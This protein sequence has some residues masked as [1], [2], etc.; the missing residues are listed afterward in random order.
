LHFLPGCQ[1]SF[2]GQVAV[3]TMWLL[4][5]TTLQLAGRSSAHLVYYLCSS[6]VPL[7]FGCR[8]LCPRRPL[9]LKHL[10]NQSPAAQYYTRCACEADTASPS[11]EGMVRFGYVGIVC[12]IARRSL[13]NDRR[14]HIRRSCTRHYT[15]PVAHRSLTRLGFPQICHA[16][17]PWASLSLLCLRL[18]HNVPS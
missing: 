11:I 6:T 15:V 8:F 3:S 7:I 18:L 10:Y 5:F 16:L 2:V 14:P 4:M 1:A 12:D 13:A 9:V 17:S